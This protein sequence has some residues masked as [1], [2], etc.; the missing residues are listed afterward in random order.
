MGNAEWIAL[1]GLVLSLGTVIFMTGR[2]QGRIKADMGRELN[3][4]E[5]AF[6]RKVGQMEV[7]LRGK[8]NDVEFHLR[9]NYVSNDVFIRIIDM[10]T[11]NNENQFRILSEQL[12]RL[13]DKLDTI[14]A[15]Q[16]QLL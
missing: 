3:T 7:G 1:A 16:R 9:D 6:E 13:N 12:N 11:A 14:Q 15:G 2:G 8:I 5:L 10:A 4:I